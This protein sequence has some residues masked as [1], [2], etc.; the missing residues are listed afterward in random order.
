MGVYKA[1]EEHRGESSSERLFR[2]GIN[3]VGVW[4]DG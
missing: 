3:G 4:K 1:L 2:E